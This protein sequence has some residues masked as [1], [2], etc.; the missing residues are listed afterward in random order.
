MKHTSP[1]QVSPPTE[2]LN[3]TLWRNAVTEKKSKIKNLRTEVKA[4]ESNYIDI[5][6]ITGTISS[7]AYFRKSTTIATGQRK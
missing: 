5:F 4:A 3:N 2:E 6:A 7:S 1:L